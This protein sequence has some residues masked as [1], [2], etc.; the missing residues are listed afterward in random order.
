[1][2]A[3][4]VNPKARRMG[5]TG[6]MLIALV[7][8]ALFLAYLSPVIWLVMSSFKNRVDIFTTSP[9]VF[10]KPTLDNYTVAFQDKGFGANLQNSVIIAVI[11]SA[12]ALLVGIPAAYRLSRH[13]SRFQGAFLLALLSARLLPAMVLSVPLFVL[14]NKVGLSGTYLAVVAAHLT[15]AIPFTVWMM[16]GFFLAV[17]TSLDEAARLD[18]C[19]ETAA[20]FRVVLPLTK[21]GIAAT[22]IFLL[23][24]S[25][26]EFLFALILTSRDTATLPVGIPNLLT[27]IGTFW[28]Q[29]AAVAT[30]TVVPI[31]IFAFAVQKYMVAGLTGGALANE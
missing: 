1:M 2:T 15:F 8:V 23:I 19:S 13:G 24:N 20:F 7:V 28:G 12:V 3:T 29:I 6:R 11:S 26:N 31:C 10:F 5:R 16:R 30:V 18:G 21:G 22:A 17:P 4:T 9:T 25:W 14:A 27:P